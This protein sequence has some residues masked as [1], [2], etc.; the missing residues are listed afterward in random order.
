MHSISRRPV[1]LLHYPHCKNFFLVFSLNLASSTSKQL[2]FVLSIAGLLKSVFLP[3]L[4]APFGYWKAAMWYPW[5]LPGLKTPTLP[6]FPHTRGF[7]PSG[8]FCV[9]P[10]GSLQQVFPMCLMHWEAHLGMCWSS[11][12]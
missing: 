12:C 10:L 2:P 11:R 3:F 7:Q 6:N 8:Y 4:Q 9:P 1:S 5:R